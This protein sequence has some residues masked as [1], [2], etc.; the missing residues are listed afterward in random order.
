MFPYGS[1]KACQYACTTLEKS[2]V[3]CIDHPTPEVTHLLLDVPSFDPDGSLRGGRDLPYILERLPPDVVVIGGN[4]SH[5]ALVRHKTIDLLKSE[6]YLAHNAAI[7]ADCTLR[8]A[9]PLLGTT[10]ADS[11]TLIIG[12][13]RIGKCLG[14]LLKQIGC[15]VTFAVRKETDLAMLHALGF[16]AV[17]ISRIPA[18]LPRCRLLFNTAPEPVLH[19]AALASCKNCVLIDLASKPGIEGENVIWARGLPG[20]HTPESSGQLIAKTIL[21]I[22]KE[23]SR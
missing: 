19:R 11:P 8:V 15:S 9:A 7:T 12:W 16:Q 23:E 13:G 20:I 14:L 1:T 22:C 17:D 10:F 21:T 18:V 6:E 2:G 4:L 5:P 3:P